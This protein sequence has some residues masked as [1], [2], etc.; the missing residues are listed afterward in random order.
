MAHWPLGHAYIVT[1]KRAGQA[2][3]QLEGE[4]VP[5]PENVLGNGAYE[6]GQA[7]A[8]ADA[9]HVQLYTSHTGGRKEYLFQKAFEQSLEV[10]PVEQ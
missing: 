7:R 5:D 1:T 9:L 3:P 8:D 2:K 10:R 6:D 4:F